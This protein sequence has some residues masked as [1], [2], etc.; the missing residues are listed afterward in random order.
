MFEIL[1]LNDQVIEIL[2]RHSKS[3]ELKKRLKDLRLSVLRD[4]ARQKI[5][6]GDACCDEVMKQVL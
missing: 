2:A 6:Q 5:I 1:D 3:Y 4:E